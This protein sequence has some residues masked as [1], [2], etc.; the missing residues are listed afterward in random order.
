MILVGSI[1][2]GSIIG[3]KGVRGNSKESKE[4]K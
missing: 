2:L 4:E 1:N 3:D